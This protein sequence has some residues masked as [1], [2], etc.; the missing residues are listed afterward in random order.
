LKNLDWLNEDLNIEANEDF[1][2]DGEVRSPNFESIISFGQVFKDV[3][4]MCIIKEK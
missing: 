1:N 2:D 3:C 4:I